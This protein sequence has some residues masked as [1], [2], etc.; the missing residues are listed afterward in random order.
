[1]DEIFSVKICFSI[2]APRVGQSMVNSVGPGGID[3]SKQNKSIKM[4]HV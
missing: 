4:R 3:N 2:D 1:M